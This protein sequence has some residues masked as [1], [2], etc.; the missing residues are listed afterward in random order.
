[1]DCAI[2]RGPV[3][4]RALVMHPTF[5]RHEEMPDEPMRREVTR[6]E[7]KS[8][9]SRDAQPEAGAAE[10]RDRILAFRAELV[11]LERGQVLILTAEQRS[12]LDAHLEA[13]LAALSRPSGAA[14]LESARRISWGMRIA[15]LLGSIAIGAAV[16]LFLHRIWGWVPSAV[17]MAILVAIP[18]LLLAA[19]E[20]TFRRGFDLYYTALLATAAA[21]SF[22][23]EL[24]ALGSTFNMAPSPHALLAWA[25]F[26]LLVAYAYRLRL[27][28]G[29]GLAL[30]CAYSASLCVMLGG[31]FW[32][33]F[34]DRAG[35]LLPGAAVI[36][37]LPWIR[38]HRGPGDFDFVYRACGAAVGLTAL[39][40]LSERGDL[41]CSG[42]P[43]RRLEALIQLA[44]L[45]L[46]AG[47]VFHGF[48]LARGGL[49]NLGAL[50]FA[51]LLFVRLQAWWW[52]WMPRYLFFLSI[53]LIALLLALVFHRMRARVSRRA[54]S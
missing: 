10:R 13:E 15:T 41:C 35:F 40:I 48:R 30:L 43:P 24:N 5:E 18:L 23:L 12:R 20:I 8:R 28:L 2:A 36:Y 42:F 38:A 49:V 9:M 51:V 17:H 44:G 7:A 37:A 4:C 6:R 33:S 50:A 19:A 27:V 16:V 39:L 31:D 26:A 3:E 52:S 54:A 32:G 14:A 47:V 46:S 22:G 25:L 45:I 29:A 11:E 53:G 34:L 21:V 1:M